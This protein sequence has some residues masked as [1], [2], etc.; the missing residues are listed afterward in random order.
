VSTSSTASST[1]SSASTGFQLTSLGSGSALQITG[2]ASGL[3]TDSIVTELMAAKQ[4]PLTNLQNQEKG[5]TAAD[6]QL[7]SLQTMLETVS[8][9][10]QALLDP[11]L[12]HT[13]QAVSSS[14]STLVSA[15]SSTGAGIGGYQVS[16]TQ[17]ANSAQ[18][19]FSYSAPTSDDTITIDGQPV[20]ISAGE[21]V[22]S[23]VSSINANAN[24][25]VYAAATDS[26]T[27]V[28]SNRQTGDTGANF[29]QVSDGAGS[30]TEQTSR[31]KEGQNALWSV[32]GQSGSS[33]TNTVTNAIAGVTLQLNGV[34]TTAG[35]VTVNVAAPAPN[36]STIETAVNK[37]VTDYNSAITAI[38]TQLSTAPSA[39]DPTVGTLY[40]D[41]DLNNMLSQMRQ[42]MYGTV[43]GT[44]SGL[45]SLLDLGISTGAST[46]SGTPSSSA[47][48]GDL[49]FD[50]TT[51]ESALQSNPEGVQQ[52]L[53]GFSSSFSGMVE[54][55]SGPG[56]TIAQRISS[57]TSRMSDLDTQISEM[58]ASLADQQQ[59]LTNQFAAMEAALSSN[60]SESSWLTSQIAQ[61]P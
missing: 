51:F 57:N 27:L 53:I 61:L 29:I 14:N 31:A 23:L 46:G 24:L 3:D 17:L 60:Q 50:A 5:L 7:T 58:Q 56:G 26:G 48:A 11:S 9:D 49:S 25:D 1:A 6:S 18:R 33:S 41:A 43:S 39:S 13:T 10:A 52:L 40:D 16:V 35:P 28:L 54:A 38:Q 20:T 21:S 42:L 30:L 12:F 19:T 59:Q 32:D 47:L 15:S 37:F 34:T 4:V 36:A 22:S 44:Q 2:L 55:E 8:A 45:S